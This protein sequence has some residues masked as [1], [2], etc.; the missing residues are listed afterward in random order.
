MR[1]DILNVDDRPLLLESRMLPARI[2]AS[3]CHGQHAWCSS[4]ECQAVDASLPHLSC[5]SFRGP[6][7]SLNRHPGSRVRSDRTRPPL[8]LAAVEWFEWSCSHAACRSG[9]HRAALPSFSSGSCGGGRLVVVPGPRA[10]GSGSHCRRPD[11]REHT[12]MCRVDHRLMCALCDQRGTTGANALAARALTR[13][14]ARGRPATVH[15]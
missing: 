4:E 10:A 12:C 9:C 1:C 2:I 7:A 13:G 8:C 6:C 11:M 14:R 5:T 15:N 3:N